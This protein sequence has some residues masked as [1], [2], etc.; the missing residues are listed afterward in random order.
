MLSKPFA[1]LTTYLLILGTLSTSLAFPGLQVPNR[2]LL[3]RQEGGA[4]TGSQGGGSSEQGVD[5][6][7]PPG[8]P[9]FTGTKLVNDADHPWQPLREGDIRGPCPGLNTLA[10]HGYLPR[11]GVATPAQIITATQEGF[12]FENN[13]AIVATY[14]GHLLNGNLVT[15]LL[16]IGGA[17]PKT[18]PPPPPP[19]H[20]GGLNVHG[21]FEGDA[22][23]TRADE[24]FGDNHSFN[25]TLFDKFV[26]FSNRY[27]GGFYNLT[28]AGELRYSRI[29]DSI[30]TNPEFQ[31]KN[32]RF[33]TAYGE[34]VF[35][36]NLFVDGRVTTDR[37]LSMEDAASIFRDMRFPDDFHRSAVPA[38]NENADQVLA[39]HPW[40][41]GGNADN[42]VNN[43]VED[44]NSAD[45]THLCR[46][47]EFV[48]GSVQE[49]YPN[50]TGIL[51]R[52]LIKNLHYWWT[53]VNVAFGGCDE[54]FPYG[55]L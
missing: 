41:P 55:Q 17:T 29:Q 3:R 45:F 7:P 14:L 13:A 5:P 48:V 44:P 24:F 54:L 33:I 53:G 51:R 38:S 50:P 19:A 28:V 23:M 39:A 31:F 11:D 18:G 34:T 26:D 52:N 35:P 27:G 2:A 10:S 37:K 49:L 21:T 8:P 20:A 42:Q 32:V 1:I 43:Y 12:N 25:Q 4:S 40:V 6:P 16:S 9:S 30:A 22:G 15:D 46:L 47:Y 36:I